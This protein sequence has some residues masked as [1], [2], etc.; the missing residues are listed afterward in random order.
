MLLS[1]TRQ[2]ER[3]TKYAVDSRSGENGLLND[4]FL[5]CSFVDSAANIGIFPFI[6]FA[7]DRE[8]DVGGFPVLKWRLDTFQQSDRPQVDVLLKGA[9]NWNQQTPERN[10]IRNIRASD[11]AEIYCIKFT[12]LAETIGRHHL[13]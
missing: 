5:F 9:T 2:I 11:C 6:V 7:D 8:I 3:E 10:V 4:C 12:K 13:A 1:G